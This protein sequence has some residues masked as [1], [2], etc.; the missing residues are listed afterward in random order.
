MIMHEHLGELASGSVCVKYN[1]VGKDWVYTLKDDPDY[2]PDHSLHEQTFARHR[3]H[4]ASYDLRDVTIY[5]GHGYAIHGNV[6]YHTTIMTGIM[7]ELTR[8]IS[9]G[10]C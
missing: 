6:T 9:N 7:V 8:L 4:A 2:D 10:R 1:A 3:G 5:I